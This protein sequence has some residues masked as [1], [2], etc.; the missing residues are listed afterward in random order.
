METGNEET[1][2]AAGD[3]LVKSINVAEAPQHGWGHVVALE[4]RFAPMVERLEQLA[5][6]DMAG[7]RRR[8]VAAGLLGY[9]VLGGLTL[10]FVAL[11]V[12]MIFLMITTHKAVGLEI[13]G[14]L[15]FGILA[16]VLFRSLWI[17]SEPLD[18]LAVTSEDTP[19]LFATLD[20]LRAATGGP[21]LDTVRITDQM[22]ASITQ[23]SRSFILG[24]R[25]VLYLGLPLLQGMRQSEVEAIIAHEFGHFVGEHG[26]SAGFAYG[27]RMRWLQVGQRLPTGV[28]AELLQNFFSWY[29]PWFAS[30]S[31]VL[32]R[33]QEY[34]ADQASA[35]IAGPKISADALIRIDFL[36]DQANRFWSTIWSQAP[37]RDD[38][39]RSPYRLLGEWL[40][41][42]ETPD[43]QALDRVLATPPD[44]HDTHPTLSQRLDALGVEPRFPPALETPAAI[45]LLGD[46][47]E[48]IREHF[49][50]DWHATADA[51]WADTYQ[52][53]QNVLAERQ[54]LEALAAT[55]NASRNDLY[56]LATCVELIDGP[57]AGAAA[58]ADVLVQHPGAHDARFRHGAALLDAGNDAGINEALSA[59]DNDPSFKVYAL[60]R[61][62]AYL[63]E[64]G[65]HNEAS[66]YHRALADAEAEHEIA[67][68]EAATI[69]ESTVLRAL[70]PEL[71]DRLA[72]LAANVEG[73]TR[74]DAAQ[75]DLQ[76]AISSQ[77][78]FVFSVAKGNDGSEVLDRLL[79]AML[80]AGDLIGIERSK[81]RKWLFKR[82]V[83][84][85]NSRV[86]G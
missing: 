7:Y 45:P 68:Q 59:A 30:Y 17:K 10:M 38:P 48:R 56:Q 44:L 27:I 54:R 13:R 53:R 75:R 60:R 66:E 64:A 84:L 71:R 14:M 83:K 47:L 8:V 40:E 32:A 16:L 62:V 35:S 50:S 57:N 31:F 72:K 18:G 22:N 26:H 85:P 4:D 78:V 1:Y 52:Q 3:G 28:V 39:P 80:P 81:P 49:D 76:H 15:L 74:V 73:V 79:D 36:S 12:L 25:N 46:A 58:F 51:Y 20:R 61:I 6:R 11:A 24:T 86:I 55:G 23:Q 33:R 9:L 19:T 34:E 63:H 70:E 43:A 2:C 21:R 37:L 67:Q 77:I 41:E 82:I 65:R 69:N 29:G 5:A 42:T